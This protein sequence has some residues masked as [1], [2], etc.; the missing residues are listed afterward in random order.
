MVLPQPP[1]P[2]QTWL[3]RLLD[4]IFRAVFEPGWQAM[5]KLTVLAI[6]AVVLYVVVR[7]FG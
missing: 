5:A 3:N 7:Q 4:G 6:V 2:G 1:D